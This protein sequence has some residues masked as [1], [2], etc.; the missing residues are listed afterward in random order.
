MIFVNGKYLRK[1]LNLIS[2]IIDNSFV[3]LCITIAIYS[4]CRL[5]LS[6]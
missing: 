2:I 6:I 1:Y 3:T 4:M 5:Y